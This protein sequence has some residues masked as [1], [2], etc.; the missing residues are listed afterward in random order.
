LIAEV[1]VDLPTQQTNKPF[2]YLIPKAWQDVICPGMRVAV[3][4]GPRKLMGFVS[5]IK[6]TSE[7]KQLKPIDR[8]MDKEPVLNEELLLLGE[9]LAK[10]TICFKISAYQA[11][12]PAALKGKYQ[13]SKSAVDDKL[14]VKTERV[15]QALQPKEE[16]VELLTATRKNA[17]NQR[18][19]LEF[20]IDH[21][22]AIRVADLIEQLDISR[23]AIS[24]LVKKGILAEGQ[25]ELYRDPYQDHHFAQTKKLVLT[26]EQQMALQPIV[27]AIDHHQHVKQLLFG[28]TGSGKTEVYLQAIEAV[29]LQGKQ[30]IM[31][32]PEIALTPQMVKRF[33]ER[34]GAQVAVLHSRLSSG[35][36]YDE[37][38]RIYRQEVSVVVGARSAV[39][40][41]FHHLGIIIIDEEHEGSYKQ[42]E[43][44][45]YHT[46]DVAIKRAEFHQCPVVMGSA[47]PSL[48]SFARARKGVYQLLTLEERINRR[49][50]PTVSI[51]DMR[52]E[53]RNNNRSMFSNQLYDKIKDRLDKKEQI[54]LLLNRRGYS[55]FVMCRD[56]GLVVECPNCAVSMTYHRSQQQMKCHYCSLEQTVPTACPHCESTHIRFFGSGTQKIEA[57]INKLFPD[58]RVIRMD[59]DTTR[60]KGA[61]E[62]LL[63]QFEDGEA[64]ILLGTQMIAKGLDFPNITLVG[65]LSAD[66]SLY[67]ADFRAA[68]RTF[69]LLTQVAGRAGRHELPGEVVVQTYTPEHYSIELA[70]SQD[71]RQF[72][73]RE[74]YTRKAA[75]FV[76]F[77]YLALVTVSH[78]DQLI[79]MDAVQTAVTF[80][81]K[82]ISQQAVVYGP[83]PSPIAR[84]NNRYRYQC[85]IKYKIEPHLLETLTALNEQFSLM[86]G[87]KDVY[88]S[89][90]M[91]P[92]MMM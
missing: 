72:Y 51:V 77:Y 10:E 6:E 11:M 62:K 48:E 64:D 28:V 67:I 87:K 17:V 8:I 82:G 73:E 66:T 74:M 80:I 68:E 34:F 29:L 22:T 83:M 85:L 7:F 81:K 70:A 33:K 75:A 63:K 16:L 42:E 60:T 30:A 76:P 18:K 40:A 55:S 31:L 36:K 5:K 78:P 23:Q 86:V 71:Y 92:N 2:D 58:A 69:Q 15:V 1:I 56:C 91:N 35:E 44:P 24:Q 19:L 88:L 57:E 27:H 13:K 61:H 90:D 14:K 89:I 39:F 38:R 21:P 45:R 46:R 41:P 25:V 4:F 37:W 52:E 20:F 79:A 65:V 12:L 84:V 32:V 3:P 47:T 53:L 50:L 54:V 26:S 59:V 9:W 43:T 49:E